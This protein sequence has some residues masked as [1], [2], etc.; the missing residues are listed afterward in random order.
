M[1]KKKPA[2]KKKKAAVPTVGQTAKRLKAM[3]ERNK[4]ALSY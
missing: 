1:P 4:K 3:K 2:P